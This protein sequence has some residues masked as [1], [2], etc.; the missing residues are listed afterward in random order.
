MYTADDDGDAI[1][2]RQTYIEYTGIYTSNDDGNAIY[3]RQT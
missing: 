1:Y 2:G 3:G